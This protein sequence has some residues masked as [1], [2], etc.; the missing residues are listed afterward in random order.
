MLLTDRIASAVTDA[1]GVCTATDMPAPNK[2]LSPFLTGRGLITCA[3]RGLVASLGALRP[4]GVCAGIVF[5]CRFDQRPNL[6]LE[7]LDPIGALD[8]FGAVPFG[9]VGGIVPIVIVA[10]DFHRSSEPVRSDFLETRV[11][12]VERL[13]SA[14]HVFAGDRFLAGDLLRVA[15]AFRDNNR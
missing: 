12:D 7:G 5:S 6:A 10:R 13:K 1:L 9:H 15:N 4:A 14:S 3:L 2:I 11:V 8:P